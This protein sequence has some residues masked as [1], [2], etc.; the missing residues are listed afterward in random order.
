MSRPL[1]IAILAHSTLPRG[2]V[3]H[4]MS[5]SEALTALGAR[6]A[7]HAPDASGAGFFRDAACELSPF[8]VAPAP[9]GTAE[10]VERRI[11]DYLDWFRR[12]DA[13]GF[14]VYH[15][16]DGISGN[17]LATLKSEGL[18][19]GFVRTVHHIDDFA[20]PRLAAWQARSI[21]DADALMVVS[22]TWRRRLKEDFDRHAEIA[23][24]GVDLQK[25][26]PVRNGREADLRMRW[27]LGDGPV[28]LAVGG[29]EARKNTVRMLGAF[30][31]LSDDSPD[32]R[33]VIVGGASLLDHGDYQ[34]EFRAALNGM[35]PRAAGVVL[36]G[37][38]ADADMPALYRLSSVLVFA[39]VKEGFGLCVLEAMACRTPVVVACMAPFVE[40]L[41]EGDAVFCD[42]FDPDSIAVAMREAL[43]GSVASRLR[44]AG[45]AVAARHTWRS[46]AETSLKVYHRLRETV[47]A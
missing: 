31:Q 20:D 16:H 33:L 28:F 13:R 41:S 19:D 46:V 17:A 11:A 7:L 25:F 3:V 5:L 22:E 21:R 24:N 36:T 34:R 14:D 15:A 23:G 38:I 30:A 47:H 26:S 45:L 32:A 6:A 35:G 8:P 18:I 4:A 1:R 43:N 12:P 10:M 29:V 37:P 27:G 9:R 44:E 40:Y 42:P 39:S 2:G